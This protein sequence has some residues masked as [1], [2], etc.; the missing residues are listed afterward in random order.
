MHAKHQGS[1]IVTPARRRRLL[2]GA[3]VGLVFF[4]LYSFSSSRSTHTPAVQEEESLQKGHIQEEL[5]ISSEQLP[6]SWTHLREWERNLP[7]HDTD[8]PSPEGRNG[9]YVSFANQVQGLGWN[10]QLNEVYVAKNSSLLFRSDV[11]TV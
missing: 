9:R 6:P 3:L 7:Q 8:L 2:V 1:H 4:S 5:P 11:Y 10:N